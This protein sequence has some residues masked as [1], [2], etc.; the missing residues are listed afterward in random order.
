MTARRLIAVSVAVSAIVAVTGCTRTSVVV[1]G[2][3][4]PPSAATGG[5]GPIPTIKQALPGIEAFVEQERGLKFKRPVKVK[6]LAAKA[7][8]KQ[9]DKGDGAPSKSDIEQSESIFYS[10]GLLSPKVNIA[11]VF[12]DAGDDT[13]IGFYDFKTKRLYVR[14][15]RATPGVRAVLSHELTHALTDQWFGLNRPK[16]DKSNQELGDA[17][18]GLIEG[19][20]ERT[21]IAYEHKVLTPAQRKIAEQ[22]ENAGGRPPH[23]PLVIL[24]LIG[25]P[26]AVGPDFVDT[27]VEDGGIAELNHAY[28]HPP[29]SSEQL[30]DPTAYENHDNPKHV[31]TPAADGTRVAHG[32]LGMIGL[33]LMLEHGLPRD[34]AQQAMTGWGGDQFA[35]WRSGSG[36]CLRDSVVMDYGL[37]MDAFQA[38]LKDWVKTRHGNAHIEQLGDKTTFVTCS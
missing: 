10:L 9:L 2:R 4:G 15:T 3:F 26:Y 28:R 5:I 34:E 27:L 14:G 1:S 12:K 11:K 35:S 31:A 17:F 33:L 23:V 21:R 22:E 18:T 8:V 13:T 37:A 36:W 6:L 30:I 20:A 32:D 25:F 19:D 16:L 29:T 7:F 38:G 24:E